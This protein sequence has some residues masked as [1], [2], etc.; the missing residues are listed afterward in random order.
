MLVK[1]AV[2]S[3]AIA[4][5]LVVPSFA[6]ADTFEYDYTTPT[7]TIDEGATPVTG[8][9]NIVFTLTA[10]TLPSSGDVYSFTSTSDPWGTITEFAWDSAASGSCLGYSAPGL[11]C[12]AFA[13]IPPPA[14]GVYSA[15]DS[16]PAG[17]F[18]TPGTYT[19][20]S[21]AET[22]VITDLGPVAAPEPSSLLLLGC[23]L[24]GLVAMPSFR[25][26]FRRLAS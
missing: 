24:L 6:K 2:L 7:W 18:L 8:S 14:G 20:L 3:L 26:R 4:S 5:L 13:N 1:I 12:A 11:A 22:F 25:S 10:A 23:G 16:F 17:S 15:W 21:S 9:L 19:G